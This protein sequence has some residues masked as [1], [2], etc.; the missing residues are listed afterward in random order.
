MLI[1]GFLVVH[2][3]I[4]AAIGA[5]AVADPAKPGLANA[6]WLGWWPTALGR[7]WLLDGLHLGPGAG[8]AGGLLWLAAGLALMAAGLGRFGVPGL[9][10]SWQMLA[11]GGAALGLLALAV[12][13]HPI[14][15]LA[16]LINVAILVA[17]W[18][19]LRPAPVGGA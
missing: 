16:T 12:Y 18:G 19:A 13:F 1:A 8:V 17:T 9:H 2:G 6:A 15:V 4:T 10:G 11:L 5:G 3:L 14:Y 7:S